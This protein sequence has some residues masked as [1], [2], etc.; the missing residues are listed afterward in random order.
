M[1]AGGDFAD[2]LIEQLHEEMSKVGHN[3]DSDRQPDS[4]MSESELEALKQSLEETLGTRDVAMKLTR[5]KEAA[6]ADSAKT[7]KVFPKNYD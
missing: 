3:T 6:A 4:D 2:F 5:A 1:E 7:K